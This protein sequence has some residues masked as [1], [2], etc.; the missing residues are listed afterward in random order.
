MNMFISI[1]AS[2]TNSCLCMFECHG[3]EYF[4]KL[5]ENFAS[6]WL[7]ADEKKNNMC[8]DC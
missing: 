3:C 5:V 2:A 8:V 1:Y 6:V 7:L 4:A